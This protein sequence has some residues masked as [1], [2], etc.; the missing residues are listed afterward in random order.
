M[1]TQAPPTT[2][3]RQSA[4]RP[5]TLRW[6]SD[7]PDNCYVRSG[8]NVGLVIEIGE[9]YMTLHFK[10]EHI[11]IRASHTDLLQYCIKWFVL[12]PDR[13]RAKQVMNILDFSFM[14]PKGSSG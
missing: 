13:Q 9:I 2:V 3:R 8:T 5:T 10:P 4:G 6:P 1:T 7:D 12:V 11:N 14:E